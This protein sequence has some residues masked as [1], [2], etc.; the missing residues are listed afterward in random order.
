MVKAVA[1]RLT[2]PFISPRS[3][4]W[5]PGISGNLVVKSKLPPRSGSSLEAVEPHPWK[6]AIK[7]FFQKRFF[8]GTMKFRFVIS[9]PKFNFPFYIAIS[10]R[11]FHFPNSATSQKLYGKQQPCVYTFHEYYWSK[12]IGKNGYL[13]SRYF[14]WEMIVPTFWT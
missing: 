14:H 3:I 12:L 9:W 8:S 2:Q 4:K 13:Y 6:G 5:V 1:P 10:I 7:F 11:S